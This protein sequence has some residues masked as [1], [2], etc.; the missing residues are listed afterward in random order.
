MKIRGIMSE[1]GV[2]CSIFL[3]CILAVIIDSASCEMF[4]ERLVEPT[5]VLISR[6]Q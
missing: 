5:N 3:V 2:S 4:R 1:R 6:E